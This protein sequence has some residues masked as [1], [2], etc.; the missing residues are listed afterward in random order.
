MAA[1]KGVEAAV[2]VTDGREV[3]FL[4]NHNKEN[5]RIT[6]NDNYKDLLN[7]REYQAGDSIE[8]GGKGVYVLLKQAYAE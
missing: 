2:R 4:L 7:G 6:L 3:F 5:E 8:I 1:P